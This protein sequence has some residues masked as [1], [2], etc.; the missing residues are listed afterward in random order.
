MSFD[1]Y[2]AGSQHKD[3]DVLLKGLKC[4]RLFS[5]VNEKKCI[6]DY[7]NSET[8]GKLF[9]D[10]GAFSVAHSGKVVDID[11]YISFINNNP[12]VEVWAQLDVIPFPVLDSTTAKT[13]A[14]ASWKNYLYM[15][16]RITID[17][18]K[19]LPI[20]HFGEPVDH[21]KRILNTEVSG[22]LPDY[23]GVGGRHGVST[24]QQD[25]Y[26]DNVFKIVKESKN[27]NVKIHAFG[28]TVFSLLEKYPFY[29]A[30]STTWLMVGA[31]GGIIDHEYGVINISNKGT[32][33]KD[34]FAH[35]PEHIKEK[36]YEKFEKF[37]YTYEQLS[38]NYVYRLSY[39]IKYLKDWADNYVCKYSP[40]QSKLKKL[41]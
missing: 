22:K 20:Y 4:C 10:S 13:C 9:I 23:I 7:L 34:N 32:A 35:M 25:I 11:E 26:F 40:N 21:L 17:K 31:N 18:D 3:T 38:D 12:N 6:S 5:Q 2:F 39:N 33:K 36:M 37:G 30:D 28:M 27:P 16:D 15:M 14:D 8:R 24:D 1:L 41:F 19:L 29:S